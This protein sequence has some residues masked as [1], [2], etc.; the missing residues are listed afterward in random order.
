MVDQVENGATIFE[1]GGFWVTGP[2]EVLCQ[3]GDVGTFAIDAPR[4]SQNPVVSKQGSNGET[5]AGADDD[6]VLPELRAALQP[7]E[8]TPRL[9]AIT[10]VESQKTPPFSRPPLGSTSDKRRRIQGMEGRRTASARR[11]LPA[12]G[13]PGSG[14]YAEG[15]VTMHSKAVQ[16][17]PCPWTRFFSPTLSHVPPPPLH[18]RS[19]YTLF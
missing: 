8:L 17:A 19:S 6:T 15:S 14:P 16:A 13:Q 7:S 11:R 5:I 1:A 18:L 9:L 3:D 10:Q 12:S 4:N 2:E